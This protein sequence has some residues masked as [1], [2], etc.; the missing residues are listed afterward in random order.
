[1]IEKD[2][3]IGES[4]VPEQNNSWSA[5]NKINMMALSVLK[6]EIDND[7][8]REREADQ[9]KVNKQTCLIRIY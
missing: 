7:K 1:M 6:D 2:T 8:S 4:P 5:K 9:T 3:K